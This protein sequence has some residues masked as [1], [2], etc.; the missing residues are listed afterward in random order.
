V[1]AAATRYKRSPFCLL[2][3][4]GRDLLARNCNSPR[5]FRI[6]ERY[7]GILHR[8]ADWTTA[9]DLAPALSVDEATLEQAMERLAGMGLVVTCPPGPAEAQQPDRQ[10]PERP[11]SEATSWNL[12]DLAMQRQSSRGGYDPATPRPG[13]PPPAFKPPPPRATPIELSRSGLDGTMTLRHALDAR[14]S[15][16]SYADADLSLDDL[17]R[18]LYAAA[19]VIGTEPDPVLGE[20]SYRPSPSGGGRHPLEL[21]PVCNAVT[22]LDPGAY[23]YDPRAHALSLVC[24][25]DAAQAE[26]N[27]HARR[28]TGDVL[29]RDPPVIIVVT[30]VFQR[31][32]WK[33]TNIALALIL[34]DVGALYQT[35]YL[36]ATGLG[37]A[38]CALGGWAEDDNA[39]WLGLDPLVESQVGGFLLGHPA[40]AH[41]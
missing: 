15:L 13:S 29:N 10:Q 41:P 40:D 17:Q 2:H 12:I 35:M 4:E 19:R 38:P 7:V 16:R 20:Q 25:A 36:V 39:R 34:K 30:A 37:L 32:M 1:S 22:G 28:A 27:A 6:A 14:R 5:L 33:Y 11:Q 26:M 18:F 3:W 24:P 31:T 9:A 23:H 8:L 21:Y